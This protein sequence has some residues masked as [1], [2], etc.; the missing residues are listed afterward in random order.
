[1]YLNVAIAAVASAALVVG[2]TLD[3]RTTPHQTSAIPGKPPVPKNLPLPAGPKI[4]A[5]FARW[6]H[7]SLDAMQRLGI[8]YA[9]RDTTA[10]RH[11]SA[12]VE[13]YRGF[14]LFW[15]GYPTDAES[16]L[17]LAK[18]LGRNTPIQGLADT[19]LHPDYFQPPSGPSYPVF[20]PLNHDALLEQ[21]SQLQQQGHQVSAE[22]VY[23][24]AA[25]LHPT[26]DEAQVAVG[27]ALFDEDNLNL[28]FGH[29]GPLT[30]QFPKSQV[31]HYYLALLLAWTAQGD[32]AVKQ[33]EQVVKLGPGTQLGKTATNALR[34]IAG[35]GTSSP[36]K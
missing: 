28:A 14:A 18:K 8:E 5:A 25:R 29:L 36:S 26:D 23:R 15:A 32:K 22:A 7:G 35:S 33:F 10:H 30:A 2:L 12:L 3:T 17:E 16:A 24:K 11:T 13:Y 27:V 19:F 9:Q 31:V 34:S 4:E 6:P 1:M 21:G 20:V